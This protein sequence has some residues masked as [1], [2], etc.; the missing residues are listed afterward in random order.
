MFWVR[1][2]GQLE[3]AMRAGAKEILVTGELAGF[4]KTV[5]RMKAFREGAAIFGDARQILGKQ[6]VSARIG[7]SLILMVEEPGT[8]PTRRH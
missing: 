8:L 5:C 4:A 1:T 6:G 3:E 7:S 2:V